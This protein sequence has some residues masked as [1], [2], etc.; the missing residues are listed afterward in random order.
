MYV[1]KKTETRCQHEGTAITVRALDSRVE[2]EGFATHINR[3]LFQVCEA[4][5][6]MTEYL[7]S[8]VKDHK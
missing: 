5:T 8:R 3:D 2:Y 7:K 4:V 1:I 6:H